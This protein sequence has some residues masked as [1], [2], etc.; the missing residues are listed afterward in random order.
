ML[1]FQRLDELITEHGWKYPYVCSK[2]GWSR[3]RI[4]DW[5]RGQSKPSESDIQLLAD[6]LDTTPEYLTDQTDAKTKKDP[7]NSESNKQ[8]ELTEIYFNLAKS[9]QDRNI[10]PRDIAYML[11]A[12]EKMK[13]PKDDDNK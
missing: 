2:F 6:L 7:P 9:A 1:N 13:K 12:I 11:D 10:D 4:N 5:K 3:V 8:G